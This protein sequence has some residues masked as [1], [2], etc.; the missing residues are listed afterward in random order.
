ML[1][2]ECFIGA[3]FTQMQDVIRKINKEDIDRVVELLFAA[4]QEEKTVFI[5]GNGGSAST[6]TH[7]VCDLAKC[8]IVEG[9]K[10][11]RVIGLVDNIPWVSALTND[12]GFAAVFEEQLKNLMRDGDVLIGISVHGGKGEDQAGVWSENLLR[13][14]KY[15]KQRQGQNIGLSGFDGGTMKA[16]ADVC[17]VVPANSTPQVESFHLCLEHLIC[18]CLHERIKA[19]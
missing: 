19:L 1:K 5:M 7:F 4:W 12:N 8:T 11:F 18:S 3:Y 17:I 14:M 6:A 16:L 15:V 10:R 9:K 2:N 13:A